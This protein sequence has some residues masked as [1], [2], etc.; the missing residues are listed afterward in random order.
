MGYNKIIYGG[1][2]LMDLTSDSVTP[3]KL[4][5]GETAHDKSGELIEGSCTYDVDSKGA[6]AVASE[7]LE[8]KTAYARGAEVT[9]TMKNNGGVSATISEKDGD[10]VIPIGYHDGSGTVAIDDTEKAKLIPDNI[11][12]GVTILGVI[13]N[14]EPSSEVTAQVKNVTPSTEEQTVLPDEGTD[15][16][17][18]VI[19][20]AIP[21]SET[22]NSAGGT[23][24]TIAG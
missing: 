19:V 13:G 21:Y 7:I 20:A 8:D 23:T 11:K 16:L 10:Y 1:K 14:C 12:N 3:E 6:T 9:G 17:S 24:V 5:S 2:T 4:L 18:Q 22:S 15:Y